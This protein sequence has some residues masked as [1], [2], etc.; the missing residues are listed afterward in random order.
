MTILD[1][2]RGIVY[3][4]YEVNMLHSAWVNFD[5]LTAFGC[6]VRGKVYDQQMCDEAWY[7]Y[8]LVHK[9]LNVPPPQPPLGYTGKDYVYADVSA[10]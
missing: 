3:T 2:I 9:R 5:R 8:V 10:V 6:V 4:N 1:R 7:Q